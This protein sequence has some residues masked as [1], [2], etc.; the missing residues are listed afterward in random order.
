[1]KTRILVP[2]LFI[3]TLFGLTSCTT[4]FTGMYGMKKTKTVDEKT[5]ARFAKKY[6]VPATDNYELDTA[7][8]SYL[9][10]LDTVKYKQE[11]NNQII[12][13]S[14]AT[15]DGCERIPLGQGCLGNNPK[16]NQSEDDDCASMASRMAVY[17][18]CAP[19]SGSSR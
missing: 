4:I 17:Q 2:I 15:K 13:A 10:S 16:S 6:N 9:F 12:N 19:L 18:A 3:L 14:D 11:I 8:F 1:M 5:I 7:Y